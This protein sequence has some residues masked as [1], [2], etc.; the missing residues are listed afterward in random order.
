VRLVGRVGDVR[1]L[2]AD[3]AVVELFDEVVD[4][5]FDGPNLPPMLRRSTP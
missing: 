4:V 5:T 2:G 3:G 1:V